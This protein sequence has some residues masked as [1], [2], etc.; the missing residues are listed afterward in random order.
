MKLKK[1]DEKDLREA[2]KLE[3]MFSPVAMF[4]LTRAMS[5]P[6]RVDNDLYDA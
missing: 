1:C 3:A 4:F 6:A 5:S 2:K